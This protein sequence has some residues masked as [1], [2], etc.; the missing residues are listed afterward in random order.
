MHAVFI[1]RI[2]AF[3]EEFIRSWNS[4]PLSSENNQTPLQL[5]SLGD[6]SESSDSDNS[7]SIIARQLPVSQPAVDVSNLSFVPCIGLDVQVKV[8]A[9]QSSANEG[10][11]V[12]E[13][14]ACCVGTHITNGCDDCYFL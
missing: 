3:V 13:Q 11:D 1:D 5:F 4:H 2:N 9:A 10:R 7:S 6:D 8:L 14:V 12:Y